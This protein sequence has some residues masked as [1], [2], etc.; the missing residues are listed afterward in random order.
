MKEYSTRSKLMGCDFSLGVVSNNESRADALL[1]MGIQ[2]IKRIEN[3]LSEFLPHSETYRINQHAFSGSIKVDS[4]CY[5]LI[6]RCISISDL[7]KG[8]FDITVSPL[9]RLYDFKNADFEMPSQK[10]ISE[11][12]SGVGYEKIKLNPIDTSIQFLHKELKI[13]FA[14]IGKGYASDK[15]K[16]MWQKENVTSGYVNSSGDITAFGKKADGTQWKIGIANPDNRS[17][18]LLYVPIENASVAT[19][20]DYE[21][22]FTYN[23]VRYSHNINPHSGLPLTGIKSVSVFS[24]SAE[25]SDALATAIYVMG[26]DEGI[27]FANQLP[28]TH[29][30]IIDSHN[31]LT[32]TK[33]IHYE[34]VSV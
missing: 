31:Q 15:V 2:E 33:K 18:V 14:A 5:Q 26:V 21:Q 20:G 9:K 10:R 30:I 16:Q 29:A 19:S 3:L 23:G 12:L 28:K 32:L 1:N 34:A 8:S 7:T 11:T 13:S 4:E 6:D 24:P 17:K 27:S 25:L 22:Y